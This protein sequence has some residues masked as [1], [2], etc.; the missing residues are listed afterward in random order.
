[1]TFI[2]VFALDYYSDYLEYTFKYK[3]V[4]LLLI[5][6]FAAGVYLISCYLTGLLKIKDF[7]TN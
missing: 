6:G 7:K 4:Y 5:V 3:A 1:M 2:L